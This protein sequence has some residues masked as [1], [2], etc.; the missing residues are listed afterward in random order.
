[1]EVY[2]SSPL[3][4]PLFPL[5]YLRKSYLRRPPP[6]QARRNRIQLFF[7][8]LSPPDPLPPPSTSAHVLPPPVSFAHLTN[9]RSRRN[10]FS[11]NLHGRVA[12]EG[13][14]RLFPPLFPYTFSSRRGIDAGPFPFSEIVRNYESAI[15]FSPLGSLNRSWEKMHK[16]LGCFPSLPF[17]FFGNPSIKRASCPVIQTELSWVLSPVPS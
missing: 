13:R 2:R 16:T 3:S 9:H 12:R 1:M 17:L 14:P 8:L 11:E 15:L 7:F 6:S 5:Q 4:S 10:Q